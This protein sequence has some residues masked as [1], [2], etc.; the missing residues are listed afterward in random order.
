MEQHRSQSAFLAGPAFTPPNV[1]HLRSGEQIIEQLTPL[2]AANLPGALLHHWRGAAF[3]PGATAADFERMLRDFNAYP[4][5]FSPQVLQAK[6]LS[7]HDGQLLTTMR[8]RQKHILTVVMDAN[9]DI[10]FGRLDE[11]DGYSTSRSTAIYEIDAPGTVREHPLSPEDEHGFLWR[12]NTYWTYQERDGGLYSDRVR[13][14]LSLHPNRPR[15][16][17]TP[18]CRERSTRISRIHPALRLQRSPQIAVWGPTL[19]QPG[20]PH[21]AFEMWDQIRA[22]HEPAPRPYA[23]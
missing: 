8:I 13:L 2:S 16:G 19:E 1:Q 23:I 9:Y 7:Q 18:F 3:A 11:R 6:V 12:L 5:R 21:L 14:A 4:Q 20:V 17:H 15:L 22:K 10:A